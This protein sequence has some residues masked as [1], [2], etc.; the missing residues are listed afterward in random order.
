MGPVGLDTEDTHCYDIKTTVAV[1]VAVTVT[2]TVTVTVITHSF[3]RRITRATMGWSKSQSQSR[4]QSQPVKVIVMDTRDT[5]HNHTVQSS[6]SAYYKWLLSTIT[7]L[8]SVSRWGNNI[9]HRNAITSGYRS[10]HVVPGGDSNVKIKYTSTGQWS[11]QEKTE[12]RGEGGQ[13]G[14]CCLLLVTP[15]LNRSIYRR[16]IQLQVHIASWPVSYSQLQSTTV[17]YSQLQSP[18]VS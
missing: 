14:S 3:I 17:S 9:M 2:V 15:L 6:H 5:W 16:I 18:A 8:R 7:G 13:L 4:S 10:V 12:G 11:S 1:T